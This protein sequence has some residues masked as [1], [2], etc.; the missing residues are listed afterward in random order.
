M[1]DPGA[2]LRFGDLRARPFLD[3][4]AR[5]GAAAPQRVVDLGCGPGTLTPLLAARWPAAEVEALDGSPEMV[6]AAR[7]AGV[8]AAVGDVR[9]WAPPPGS[10]VVVSNAVLHWVPEHPDLLRRWV[11]GLAPDSWLGLQVPGNGSAASHTELRRVA[12][13]PRWRGVPGLREG[14]LDEVAVLDPAGYGALLEAAGARAVDAW[15]TTYAQRMT[16]DDPV[17]DW[18]SG[19]VLRPVRAVLDD[20]AWAEFRAELAPRLRAAYPAERGI[21]WFPFRRV[22]AV[23]RV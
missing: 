8:P 6:A 23:A 17:L 5:I 1:W 19:T 7:A 10:A 14:L 4:L 3:L 21:T 20:A 15:E 18:I 11:R 12:G 22:F 9:D 2:Y 16:G 13:E